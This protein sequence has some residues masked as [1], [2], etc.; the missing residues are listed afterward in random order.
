[1]NPSIIHPPEVLHQI[2][3]MSKRVAESQPDDVPASKEPR[4]ADGPS[5]PLPRPSIEEITAAG[6]VIHRAFEAA[7]DAFEREAKPVHFES[8][9]MGTFKREHIEYN[10]IAWSALDEYI[11]LDETLL[12]FPWWELCCR[13]WTSE[14]ITNRIGGQIT[15]SHTTAK[16]TLWRDVYPPREHVEEADK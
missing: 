2:T 4:V 7:L 15:N 11:D 16:L 9:D 14:M 5:P 13:D 8:D 6:L 10:P 1:M 3:G 12:E